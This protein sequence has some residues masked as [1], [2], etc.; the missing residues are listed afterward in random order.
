MHVPFFDL[1]RGFTPYKKD[2]FQEL[3]KVLKKMNL[4]LGDNVSQFETSFARYIGCRNCVTVA[5]GT[6]A[7]ILALKAIGI[8]LGDEVITVPNTF[9]ATAEAIVSVGAKPV[10]VDVKPETLLLDLN[11]LEK[12][13]TPKTRALIPVHLYGQMP[14]MNQLKQF[15]QKHNLYLI[16]DAAQAHGSIYQGKK[17]GN[18]GDVGCFSFYFTKNLGAYGEGGCVTT[19][20]PDIAEK[21]RALRHHGQS[22]KNEHSFWGTNSRMD[23]IQALI[24]N[25][26]LKHLDEANQKRID[27]AQRY[28][29]KLASHPLTLLPNDDPD[30]KPVFYVY[31]VRTPKR[32]ALRKYLAEQ[33]IETGVHYPVPVHKQP[34]Y[35]NTYTDA[36]SLPVAEKACNEIL[37]LPFFPELKTEEL[38]WVAKMV[39]DFFS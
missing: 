16:E 23:E 30:L 8:K 22:G 20:N 7:L 31:V 1:K 11:E 3:E 14:A 13:L 5:S 9:F 17:A 28:N 4:C 39:G 36:P 18:W 10:F 26:K 6:D 38:D 35:L 15:C 21:L 34:A 27:L 19:N 37:S 2:F 25:L 33:E 12:S 32:D 24:L 29:E